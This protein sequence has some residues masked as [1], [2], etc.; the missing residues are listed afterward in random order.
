VLR[1]V[2]KQHK[3]KVPALYEQKVKIQ[4][5][6]ITFLIIG[7][8][9]F[10]MY[11]TQEQTPGNFKNALFNLTNLF[12][13]FFPPNFRILSSVW[14]P[15]ADTIQMAIISTTIA[16]L[17]TIPLALLGSRNITP[18][19]P[20]YFIA[21]ASLNLIRLIPEMVLAI[22]FVGIFGVGVISG[23][24]A[25]IIFSLGVL[26]KLI[27]ETIESVNMNSLEAIRA[28]GGGLLQVIFFGLFPQVL[29][30][31]TSFI[32]YVFEVNVRASVV[33]GLVGAGGIG[34][35]LERELKFYN[36]P[37][38]MAIIIVI[39]VVVIGI[40]YMSNKL[41]EALL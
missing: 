6:M 40:E 14:K 8:Y 11:W 1:R 35:M 36:Y 25:L 28:S 18:F 15:M 32:L 12:Q 16:A 2:R 3:T 30:Q 7:F 17:L 26:S 31:I 9:L 27:S 13:K 24:I 39:F 41:R 19:K 20:I 37:N 33:L 10:S 4:V 23:V 21:R 34:L 29:P 5:T 38:V 22:V